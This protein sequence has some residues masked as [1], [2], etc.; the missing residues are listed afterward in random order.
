MARGTPFAA[1]LTKHSYLTSAH[2]EALAWVRDIEIEA[3][4]G[5]DVAETK[6]KAA[7]K[8]YAGEVHKKTEEARR[9]AKRSAKD[10]AAVAK[11]Q[12]GVAAAAAVP[13][14]LPTG[15]SASKSSHKRSRKG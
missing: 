3:A 14:Q 7:L 13:H 15:Q 10:R 11:L 8:Q 12:A 1:L 5:N 9:G 4:S 2:R 6:L